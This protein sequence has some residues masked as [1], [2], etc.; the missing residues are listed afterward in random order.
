MCPINGT[1][2]Q[3]PLEGPVVEGG[4]VDL[5]R[6]MRKGNDIEKAWKTCMKA[7]WQRLMIYM[8]KPA[9]RHPG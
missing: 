5:P 3:L 7:I 6:G 9:I 2:F 4:G 8:R 1:A